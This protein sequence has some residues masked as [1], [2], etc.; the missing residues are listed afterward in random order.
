M[1]K[2]AYLNKGGM[3]PAAPVKWTC[4]AIYCVGDHQVGV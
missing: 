4:R 3:S 2:A 1:P